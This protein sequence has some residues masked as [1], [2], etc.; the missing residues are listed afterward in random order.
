MIQISLVIPVYN[1]NGAIERNLPVILDIL[2]GIEAFCFQVLLI[3]DGSTDGTSDWLKEYC[4]AHSNVELVCLSRN[5]GKEA[6]ILAGLMHAH[7]EAAIVLDSDLQHPPSL[8]PKMLAL[9]GQGFD[10]VEACKA[11]RGRE[12]LVSAMLA[13]GFYRLFNLLAGMDITNNSD[14]KLLDRRI[15]EAYCA[16]PERK[17]FFRGMIPWIGYS[18][19]RLYFDV[20]DRKHGVSAWSRFKL[21]RFSMTALTSFSSKPLHL[22]TLLGLISFAFSLILGSITLY[23]K[24]TGLAISGFTTVILMFLLIGSFIMIGLGLI[25]VYLEQIFDEIKKRPV[26]LVDTRKSCLKEKS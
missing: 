8:I 17:R 6:A 1:E 25:G 21:L 22:I 9:W 3:D 26:Y 4:L 24:F 12:T 16:L 5:F 14:F 10:V 23:Q 11:S 13:G 7:G 19:A 18:R 2:S 15:V 20:P